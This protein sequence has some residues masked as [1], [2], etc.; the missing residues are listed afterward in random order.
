MEAAAQLRRSK[1]D[2]AE[3]K[4]SQAAAPAGVSPLTFGQKLTY[5][6]GSTSLGVAGLGLSAGLVTFFMNQVMGVPAIWV[7]TALMAGVTIDALFDPL[8]GQWSD[9]VRSRL[10]RRHPFMFA[11]AP[12]AMTAAFF[13]WR[14][15]SGL[16][17]TAT[18][19]YMM[20]LLVMLR[21]AVSLYE[22]PSSAL[23]PELTADYH[24]R[25]TLFGYRWFFIIIGGLAMNAVLYLWF[26]RPANGGLLNA[27]G[28]AQWG[29]LAAVVIAVSILVCCVG[30]LSRIPA[31]PRLPSQ[32]VSLRE[33]IRQVASTV[34]NPSLVA[35][36]V[37]GLIGGVTNGLNLTLSG[38]GCCSPPTAPAEAQRRRRRLPWRRPDRGGRYLGQIRRGSRPPARGDATLGRGLSAVLGRARRQLADRP[39]LLQD[40]PDHPRGEP[41][42][43]AGGRQ[44]VSLDQLTGQNSP[45]VASV[46]R[47]ASRTIWPLTR[48][49]STPIAS[50][51]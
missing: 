33:T 29:A 39:G 42:A 11:S 7:G 50:R 31:L 47:P 2:L 20:T 27:A 16:G 1:V 6:V 37:A 43:P 35:V 49:A 8:L 21:L 30:T 44:G 12:L 17:V 15:P 5:G 4:P 48:T 14:P 40:R 45:G 19:A 22:I 9:G 36:M 18:F 3:A 25:T 46:Y 51:T 24:E 41:P 32:T 10:G 26:L 23:A 38:R 13:F 34:T 28:Y